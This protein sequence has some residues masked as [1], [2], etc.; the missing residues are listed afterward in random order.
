MILKTRNRLLFTL[1]IITTI[2]VGIEAKTLKAI[3]IEGL[4]MNTPE[5][6]KKSLPLQEGQEFTG[7]DIQN[8]LKSLY[9]RGDYKDV[10]VFL[11]EETDSS[12]TLVFILTENPLV[13]SIEIVGFK[14][15]KEKE[16]KDKL[17]MHKGFV[18][19]DAAVYE[20]IQ[21]LKAAYAEE[22][23][24]LADISC[25][26]IETKI[27]GNVIAKFKIKEG[28][29]VRIKAVTFSGNTVFTDR[30]LKRKLKTK[31][32]RWFNAGEYKESEYNSHKDTLLMFYYEKG[33]LD[34]C[35]S[36]RFCS[37]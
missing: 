6:V 13:E 12:A 37:F 28:K 21:I 19:S 14:K 20:N 36:K 32:K 27:P 35:Y 11:E 3:K 24:L 26:L 1:L 7:P 33:Y 2:F 16:L 29:K 31:E 34:A 22:G 4:K 30:K 25:D 17:T 9:R 15:L 23:Y 10:E 5:V 18:T 8:C